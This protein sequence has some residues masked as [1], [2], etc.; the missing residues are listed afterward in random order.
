[1][2]LSVGVTILI[3]PHTL[4]LLLTRKE[5]YVAQMPLLWEIKFAMTLSVEEATGALFRIPD[6]VFWTYI[7]FIVIFLL[8]IGSGVAFICRKEV[9]FESN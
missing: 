5:M 1:M 2:L 7:K 8:I 3:W 9:G 4:D 6:I